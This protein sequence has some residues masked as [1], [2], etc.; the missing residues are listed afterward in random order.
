MFFDYRGDI[1]PWQ[2]PKNILLGY[3]VIYWMLFDCRGDN[4][5]MAEAEEYLQKELGISEERAKKLVQRANTYKD[6][7]VQKSEMEKLRKEV[8]EM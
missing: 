5:P 1:F 3:L 7:K 8:T 2:R 4:I 6:N